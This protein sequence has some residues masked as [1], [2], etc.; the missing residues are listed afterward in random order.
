V[1]Y[2][3]TMRPRIIIACFLVFFSSAASRASW[4][5]FGSYNAADFYNARTGLVSI[6]NGQGGLIESF[7]DTNFTVVFGARVTQIA[8]Q[9]SDRAWAIGGDSLYLGTN[10]WNSWQKTFVDS[11]LTGGSLTLVRATPTKLFIFSDNVL[12]WTITGDTL[13]PTNGIIYGDS[14]TAM[15]YVSDSLLIAVS[16]GFIYRSTDGGNNWLDMY[17]TMKGCASVFADTA[18]HLIFTGGDN[19][20]VSADSGQTWSVVSPPPEFDIGSIVGQV[21]GARDC[22]GTLYVLG[23]I[24]NGVSTGFMRS[25]DDGNSFEEV[26]SSSLPSY[27]YYFKGWAFDRGSTLFLMSEDY[28][29]P[30]DY[31][32]FSVSHDGGDGIISDSVASAITISADT[33]FDSLCTVVSEPFSVSVA[34]SICTGVRIDS[35]SVLHSGGIVA[36]SFT[37]QIVHGNTATISLS[38]SGTVPGDDSIVLRVWFHSLELGLKEHLDV[39]AVAYT[40]SAPAVLVSTDSLQFGDVLLDTVTRRLLRITNSGCSALRVDSVVSSNPVIFSL[41]S[42]SFPFTIKGDST[43]D[44][45]VTFSPQQVGPSLESIELGTNAGH[46]FIE[47]DGQGISLAA[48]SDRERGME[49][50]FS[51]FPN[52]ASAIVSVRGID[53]NSQYEIIDLL[54][55]TVLNG[56]MDGH[57][58][59]VSALP[60]GIYLLRCVDRTA[61]I[62]VSRK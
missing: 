41:P 49:T 1:R 52:P 50:D 59:S 25:E 56:F 39:G 12:Y 57:T 58:I 32:D 15:D 7:A 20:R 47:L 22:S 8:I 61:R 24:S 53:E 2:K 3:F 35:I 28:S 29:Y 21:F 31:F 16:S 26:S 40:I 48:V 5:S 36:K 13:I 46:T 62:V 11:V 14:I 27:G 51:I 17:R 33:I 18:H 44:I 4:S 55:R 30:I 23:S 9:N 60:D 45:P 34:S 38:Y 42:L 37:P 6:N 54:G 10:E 43:V 19:L